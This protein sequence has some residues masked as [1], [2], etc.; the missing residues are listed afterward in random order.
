[1]N[2]DKWEWV[3]VVGLSVLILMIALLVAQTEM[4]A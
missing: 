4:G 2:Q 3:I 1:M